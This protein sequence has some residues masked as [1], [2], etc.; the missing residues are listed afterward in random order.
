MS[1]L[2]FTGC[3]RQFVSGAGGR[4][5]KARSA[6]RSAQDFWY[7]ANCYALPLPV[8]IRERTGA[9]ALVLFQR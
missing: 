3:E 5:T 6:S 8:V 9:P 7:G 2:L 4:G 1:M